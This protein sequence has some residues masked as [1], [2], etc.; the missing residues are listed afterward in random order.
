MD[1]F[2][3][4]LKHN[5]VAIALGLGLGISLINLPS[6]AQYAGTSSSSLSPNDRET[7]ELNSFLNGSSDGSAGSLFS[8]INRLQSL[9]GRTGQDFAEEQNENLNSAVQDFR[10]KQQEKLQNQG[11]P[12]TPQPVPGSTTP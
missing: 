8:V 5:R 12:L 10:K 9:S 11:S 6:Y 1:S 7:E 4:A 2:H 3:R